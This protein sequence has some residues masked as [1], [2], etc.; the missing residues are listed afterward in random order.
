VDPDRSLGQEARAWLVF[1]TGA[2]VVER[3]ADARFAIATDVACLPPFSVFDAGTDERPERSATLVIQVDDLQGG[4]GR[5][6]TGPGIAGRTTLDV[7]G[8]PP[9]FWD[10]LRDNHARF[11]RGVDVVLTA[12]TRLAALPRTTRVED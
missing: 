3:P 7:T 10:D 8:V 12:G 5:V 1:H 11:P 9:T 6:L 2:P 4:G